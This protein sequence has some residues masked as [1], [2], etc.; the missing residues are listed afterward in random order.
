MEHPC[1]VVHGRVK[2]VESFVAACHHLVIVGL[3]LC[4]H[5]IPDTGP[6]RA[7]LAAMV[8]D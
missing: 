5:V 8:G 1:T 3:F 7:Y 6:E 4:L 2:E